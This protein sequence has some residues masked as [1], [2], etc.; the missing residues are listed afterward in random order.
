MRGVWFTAMSSSPHCREEREAGE[1][2]GGEG[3]VEGKRRWESG[4]EEDEKGK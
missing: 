1:A 3:G 4:E 2:G